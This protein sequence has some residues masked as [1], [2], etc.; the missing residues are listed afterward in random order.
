M[1]KYPVNS[2]IP[3]KVTETDDLHSKLKKMTYDEIIEDYD[4]HFKNCYVT[5]FDLIHH[6][7]RGDKIIKSAIKFCYKIRKR[8]CKY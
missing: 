5:N 8:R 3:T 2:Y 6:E 4:C 1:E 7:C